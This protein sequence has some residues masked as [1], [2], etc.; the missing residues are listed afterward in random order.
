MKYTG[1][2]YKYRAIGCNDSKAR[3]RLEEIFI[4]GRCHF[5]EPSTLNDPFDCDP[6]T[7]YAD[8]A[9]LRKSVQ[10]RRKNFSPQKPKKGEISKTMQDIKNAYQGYSLR[11][12]FDEYIGVF[13]LSKSPLLSLQWSHYGDSHKGICLEF[14]FDVIEDWYSQEVEYTNDRVSIDL[15]EFQENDTARIE[16]LSKALHTKG[17]DWKVEQEVRAVSQS[18]GLKPFPPA[19]LK[20]VIFGLCTP[21]EHQDDI[22]KIIEKSEL[23][24]R[25]YKCTQS[26]SHYNLELIEISSNKSSKKDVVTGA[27]Y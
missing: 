14:D 22:I 21:D 11:E 4:E 8:S 24:P 6:Y 25:L 12:I 3:A 15:L 5:A 17:M 27:S 7:H 13:C 16:I 1:T 19:G 18:S 26:S 9:K 23:N 20:S 2:A 10:K